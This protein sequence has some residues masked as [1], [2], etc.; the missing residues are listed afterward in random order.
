M[1]RLILLFGIFPLL[2]I[3]Q[4]FS[5][6]KQSFDSLFKKLD[7]TGK[8]GLNDRLGTINYITNEKVKSSLK[9]VEKG[10]SVSLSFKIT[11]DSLATNKFNS[12]KLS[13]YS[14]ETNELNF[15][16]YNWVTDNFSISYHGHTH[17]HI[18]ALNHLSHNGFYYNQQKSPNELGIEN[19]KNGIITKGILIDLPL[20]KEKEFIEAGYKITSQ[21]IIDFEKK[22]N[23]EIERGD[24]L[25]IRTGRW[26]Q[27]EITGEWNFLVK[28]TGLHYNVMQ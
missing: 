8:W 14:H 20:L 22:F 26:K 13:S 23:V 28:S 18:D 3:G 19:F 6:E 2:V 27:K 12:D 16:G 4:S 17:S 5:K 7:N 11:E 9:F 10:V 15:K 25:L 24:I 1:K 21:D